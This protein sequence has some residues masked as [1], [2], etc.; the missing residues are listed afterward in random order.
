M[1][2]GTDIRLCR[3]GAVGASAIA[4][5]LGHNNTLQVLDLSACGLRTFGAIA[6]A[7]ALASN[8]ALLQLDLSSNDIGSTA[9][10]AV[11]HLLGEN[12][13]LSALALRR[14]PLGAQG[15]AAVLAAAGAGSALRKLDLEGA[16]MNAEVGMGLPLRQGRKTGAAAAAF[17]PS[18]PN[19]SYKLDLAGAPCRPLADGAGGRTCGIALTC[20]CKSLQLLALRLNH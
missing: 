9:C 4:D 15:A 17:D 16:A 2:L 3:L 19:G 14:N 6:V 11:A 18:K 5:G 1:A 20:M 13:T 8:E 10:L 12:T 7:D